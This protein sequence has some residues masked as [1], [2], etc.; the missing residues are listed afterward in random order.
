MKVL[1]E[2]TIFMDLS[3]NLFIHVFMIFIIVDLLS[4]LAKAVF[5]KTTN[6]TIGLNG[7]IRHALIVF[8]VLMFAIYLPLFELEQYVSWILGYFIVQ[9]LISIIENLGV[10][11]FPIPP[12]LKDFIYKLNDTIDLSI[13]SRLMKVNNV[14]VKTQ[15]TN[16]EKE[17]VKDGK[18][19]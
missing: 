9:Y 12:A 1:A 8:I 5:L 7:L 4:G 19:D 15:E 18:T 3:Q 13:D 10:I 14:I 11:G 16:I 6:S 2:S 17:V